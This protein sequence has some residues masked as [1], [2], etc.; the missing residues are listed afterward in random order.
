MEIII[1]N[2]LK[3]VPELSYSQVENLFSLLA[4]GTVSTVQDLVKNSGIPVSTINDIVQICGNLV[5]IK[6]NAIS[7][8]Q[9]LSNKSFD[10][11]ESD[12]LIIDKDVEDEITKI[13]VKY[14]LNPKREL[15]QFFATENTTVKKALVVGKLGLVKLNNIAILGD[16]DFV[17]IA[18]TLKY[19]NIS[20]VTVFETDKQ[21]IDKINLVAKDYKLNINCIEYNAKDLI[22]ANFKNKFDLVLTDPPYTDNGIELFLDRAIS[23]IKQNGYVFLNY[24]NSFKTPEKYIRI[25]E[26]FNKY[27]LFIKNV[28]YNFNQYNGAVSI[29]SNSSLY[30]LQSTNTTKAGDVSFKNIYTFEERDLL[31]FPYSA[32]FSFKL[33]NVSTKLL[34]SRA[35]IDENAKLFAKAH[36]LK[37]V[38]ESIHKFNNTGFT[39]NYTLST[40]SL[41]IHTWPEYKALHILIDVCSKVKNEML[42]VETLSKLFEVDIQNISFKKYL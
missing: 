7:I 30:I 9:E 2:I 21:L 28:F 36:A 4:N 42:M 40:S 35:K 24:G 19:K 18:L 16:D 37:I 34:F 38:D 33:T 20:E 1:Q 41:V 15:D 12:I 32:T 10:K 6:G 22:P 8:S 23:L 3:K 31:K 25:Q 11:L 14:N 29:G 17:S 13:R 39:F 26:I 27:S 5:S